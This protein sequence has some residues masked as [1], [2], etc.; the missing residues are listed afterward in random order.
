MIN[1]LVREWSAPN[2]PPLGLL[3]LSSVLRQ[4]GHEVKIMD[5]N[6][7]RWSMDVVEKQIAKDEEYDIYGLGGLVTTYSYNMWLADIIKMD[8]PGKIRICGGPL[9]TAK[10]DILLKHVNSVIIGEGE[11]AILDVVQDVERSRLKGIYQSDKP[12]L[13]DSLPQPDYDN[14]D[15]LPV[16]LNAAVGAHN[17]RK[18]LDGKSIRQVKTLPILSGRG[19]PFNCGFCSSHYLGPGFR[20]RSVSNI[21]KEAKGLIERYGVKY[22]HFCDEL[23]VPSRGRCL[24]LCSELAKM[25]VTWGCPV[26]I[27][28]L[29]YELLSEMRDAGCI[30]VGTGIESFSPKVLKSMGKSLNPDLAKTLLKQ[31]H[32]LMDIQYTLILG[33]IGETKETLNET[34]RGVKEIGFPPEQVFF[35]VPY[36]GTQLYGYARSYGFIEDEEKHLEALSNHEQRDLLFNFSSLS[37]E[38]L[39]DARNRIMET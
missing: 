5:I 32:N 9:T 15:T 17:P 23:T 22:L 27:D 29:G 11:E 30:H 35:P 6:G 3:Q 14:L 21:V 1:P 13:L 7:H 25:D 34:I 36:P 24:D 31:A 33:Y 10:S 18:W 16:Y 19:C 12:M 8:H 37:D 20:F 39:L 4:N 2:I 38:E 28:L 26:R